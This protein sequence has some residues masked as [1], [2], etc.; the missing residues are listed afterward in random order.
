MSVLEQ[1]KTGLSA[2]FIG[3]HTSR[4]D[5]KGRV[6]VP[7]AFR[8]A[9]GDGALICFPSFTGP[10]LD[11][12]SEDLLDTLMGMIANLDFFDERREAFELSIMSESRRLPIDGDGRI[13]LPPALQD[14]AALQGQARFVGLGARFQIWR[15]EAHEEKLVSARKVALEHRDILKARGLPSTA[16]PQISKPPVDKGGEFD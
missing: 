3:A 10:V 13:K 4:V 15:P 5:A 11:C 14:Y 16:R 12:G 7:A 8:K 9:L 2:R 1:T 6:S